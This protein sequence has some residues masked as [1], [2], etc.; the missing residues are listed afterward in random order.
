MNPASKRQ[1][2]IMHVGETYSAH[3]ATKIVKSMVEQGELSFDSP[4][5]RHNWL[6]NMI[7]YVHKSYSIEEMEAYE[8]AII[9]KEIASLRKRHASD[10]Q[11]VKV[12]LAALNLQHGCP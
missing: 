1:V 2:A 8:G 7:A 5:E 4:R 10:L 12:E 6:H 9:E 3:I 11:D